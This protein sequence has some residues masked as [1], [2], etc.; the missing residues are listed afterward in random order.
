MSLDAVQEL[1]DATTVLLAVLTFTH[2]TED[3]VKPELND[4]IVRTIYA[5]SRLRK[6]DIVAHVEA[7]LVPVWQDPA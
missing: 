7:A 5:R 6:S 3:L 4:A 2:C 1:Y